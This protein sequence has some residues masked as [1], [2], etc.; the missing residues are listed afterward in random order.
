M[1]L[2]RPPPGEP[3]LCCQLIVLVLCEAGYGSQRLL[4]VCSLQSQ[5][6]ACTAPHAARGSVLCHVSIPPMGKMAL[7]HVSFRKLKED[8]LVPIGTIS[9]DMMVACKACFIISILQS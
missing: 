1:S 8:A 7:S 9:Y 3:A 4:V 6:G 2:Q 5:Q